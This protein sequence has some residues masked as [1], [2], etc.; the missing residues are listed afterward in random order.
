MGPVC[1]IGL[2]EQNLLIE[3]RIRGEPIPKLGV[4]IDL[5]REAI[6]KARPLALDSHDRYL[7]STYM[8]PPLRPEYPYRRAIELKADARPDSRCRVECLVQVIDIL[9]VARIRIVPLPR[10]VREQR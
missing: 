8:V 10:A 5:D 7:S 9:R 2:R 3:A 6:L 1:Q 4:A